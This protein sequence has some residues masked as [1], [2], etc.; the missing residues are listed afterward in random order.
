MSGLDEWRRV[1]FGLGSNLG[2]RLEHLQSAV[3]HI[4]DRPTVAPVKASKVYETD[5]VGGPDQPDFLNAVL[6]VDT[7]ITVAG[8]L[9][10]A[11]DCEAAA[12]RIRSDR[13][14]PRTLDVDVLAVAGVLSNDPALILPHPRIAEREF[15]LRPWA[16]ADPSFLVVGTDTVQD[17]LARVEP[18]G[19]RVTDLRLEVSG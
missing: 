14:G 10:L 15:V 18:G 17:L 19:V 1:A 8:L 9:N 12:G 16:D 2:N 13:W 7:T 3:T 6:V 5:P 11:H 4:L